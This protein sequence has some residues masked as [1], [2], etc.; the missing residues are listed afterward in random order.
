MFTAVEQDA[1]YLDA[2]L[3][4]NCQVLISIR[5]LSIPNVEAAFTM[6]ATVHLAQTKNFRCNNV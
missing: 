4:L 2:D 5:E 6:C 1:S 3:D